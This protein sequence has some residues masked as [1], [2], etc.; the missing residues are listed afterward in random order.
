MSNLDM[1]KIIFYPISNSVFNAFTRIA[2][3]CQY[4]VDFRQF[5]PRN[6]PCAVIGSSAKRGSRLSIRYA[7]GSLYNE[8][9]FS[10]RLAS[11]N[12]DDA[13]CIEI[14]AD[15]SGSSSSGVAAAGAAGPTKKT[16]KQAVKKQAA[17]G[18][19]HPKY[20]EMV[21]QALTS[22]KERG[23]SSRQAVL[24]YIMQHFEGVVGKEESVVNRHLKV[25][26]RAGVKN[27]SLKQSKGARGATGSFRLGEEAKKK[28][29]ATKKVA[30]PKK[31]AAA[32]KP[33]AAVKKPAAAAAPKVKK[34][35][36][37]ATTKAASSTPKKAAATAA[38]KKK[39]TTTT[40]T[41]KEGPKSVKEVG[42]PKKTTVSSTKINKAASTK[43]AKK[44]PAAA[45]PK[46]TVKKGL[47]Q[48][49]T[50]TK[51]HS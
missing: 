6:E 31:Q 18:G 2:V 24:K 17:A 11:F 8:C 1:L 46:Q 29:K 3:F 28:E 15:N 14:M 38:P 47:P 35:A 23:G 30:K 4:F 7:L 22:M 16:A 36:K 19:Q 51:A 26:L 37:K 10:S 49:K 27:A 44:T 32:K 21:K 20:S 5:L 50:V 25:A 40:S 41:K 34:M 39:L 42:K 33:A 45:P 13:W 48:K 12:Y 9:H 43:A